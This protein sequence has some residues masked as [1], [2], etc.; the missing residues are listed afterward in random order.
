MKYR[1][2]S[3]M[4]TKTLFATSWELMLGLMN[5]NGVAHRDMSKHQ[6]ESGKWMANIVVM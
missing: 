2:C 6:L 4:E 1:F 5:R 3:M